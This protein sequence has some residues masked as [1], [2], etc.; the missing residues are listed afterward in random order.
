[1]MMKGRWGRG[2][3]AGH[4]IALVVGG[5][6]ESLL[7]APESYDLVLSNRKVRSFPLPRGDN[8]N[9]NNDNRGGNRGVIII[10]LCIIT[11]TTSTTTTVLLL[12]LFPVLEYHRS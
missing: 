4:S 10:I 2:G 11:S 12:L 5:A 8:N 3:R 6:K 9:N 7:S 1:M